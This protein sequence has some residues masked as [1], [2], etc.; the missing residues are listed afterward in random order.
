MFFDQWQ[1]MYGSY[2]VLSSTIN[3]KA[4]AVQGGI[5]LGMALA[6]T[7]APDIS[8][9][10]FDAYCE[11]PGVRTTTITPQKPSQLTARWNC[12]RW[13]LSR[14]ENTALWTT[15][16]GTSQYFTVSFG[17][18]NGSALPAADPTIMV[19]MTFRALL[20]SPTM[21]GLS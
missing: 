17:S 2:S 4:S 12:K 19:T 10:F 8:V 1:A 16:P 14:T 18:L 11:R 21:P 20:S 6:C 5:N 13:G 3:V 15:N 7:T 9:G